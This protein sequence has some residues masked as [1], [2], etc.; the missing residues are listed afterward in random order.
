[1]RERLGRRPK[2]DE[3]G[4]SFLSFRLKG[5]TNEKDASYQT[6]PEDVEPFVSDD[7]RDT[8]YWDDYP[9]EQNPYTVQDPYSGY[10]G[11]TEA[12][13]GS[14]ISYKKGFY[15]DPNGTKGSEKLAWQTMGVSEAVCR[16][17]KQ[18]KIQVDG[19]ELTFT[20][21]PTS[22]Y[23]RKANFHCRCRC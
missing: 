5:I 9:P 20:A 19:V 14:G 16:D 1:M 2:T 12:A 11:G 8:G 3:T 10:S 7:L 6:A 23:M 17:N 15:D 4:T 13:A 21:Q 18:F 22:E